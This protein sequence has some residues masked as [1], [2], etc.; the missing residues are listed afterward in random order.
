[1]DKV[2]S[3]KEDFGGIDQAKDKS[4]IDPKMTKLLL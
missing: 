4:S 2:F 1:M 3:V